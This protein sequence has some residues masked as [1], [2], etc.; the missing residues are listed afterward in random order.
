[1]DRD[2]GDDLI[3]YEGVPA[4]LHITKPKDWHR[5]NYVPLSN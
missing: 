1:M 4:A 3:L 2:C 5:I